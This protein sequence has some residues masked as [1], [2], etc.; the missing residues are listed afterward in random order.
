MYLSIEKVYLAL[1]FVIQL[2]QHYL[3]PYSLKLISKADALKYIMSWLTLNRLL[4]HY[5]TEYIP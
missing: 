5:D 4:K 1:I 2:I 3:Q